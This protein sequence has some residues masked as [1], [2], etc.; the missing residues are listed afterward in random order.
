LAKAVGKEMAKK[1]P[2]ALC[3]LPTKGTDIKK[4]DFS[5]TQ[6]ALNIIQL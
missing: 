4:F 3:Q 6:Q 5:L 2:T 1:L